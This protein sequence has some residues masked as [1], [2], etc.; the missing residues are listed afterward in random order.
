MCNNHAYSAIFTF[1]PQQIKTLKKQDLAQW[2]NFLQWQD[3]S[4]SF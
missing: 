4:K 1:N 2:Q 3:S